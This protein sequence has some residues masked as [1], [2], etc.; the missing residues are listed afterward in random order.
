MPES[1]PPRPLIAEMDKAEEYQ[2]VNSHVLM[3]D[4]LFATLNDW[5]D[6]Y[7]RDRLTH[8]GAIAPP[9]LMPESVPPRPLIAEMDKPNRAAGSGST[10]PAS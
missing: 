3:N 2:A 7:Y 6:R 4:T 8:D 9:G 1:V 10:D 5:V